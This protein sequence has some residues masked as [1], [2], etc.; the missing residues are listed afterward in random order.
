[1]IFFSWIPPPRISI[2]L[3]LPPSKIFLVRDP[4]PPHFNGTSLT[5]TGQGTRRLCSLALKIEW[6]EICKSNLT[7]LTNYIKKVSVCYLQNLVWADLVNFTLS[8][9]RAMCE[10]CKFILLCKFV[11]IQFHIHICSAGIVCHFLPIHI[12]PAKYC[13]I[14]MY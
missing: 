11:K 6:W 3:N 4:L 2:H 9:S 1:M 5:N 13:N 14:S 8:R 12:L 7:V 10:I